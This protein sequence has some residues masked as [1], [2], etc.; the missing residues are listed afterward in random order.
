MQEELVRERVV[1]E[2]MLMVV[3]QALEVVL[4]PVRVVQMVLM[5]VPEA[6]VEVVEVAIMVALG[7]VVDLVQVQALVNIFKGHPTATVDILTLVETEVV[8]EEDKPEVT[9]ALAA[10]VLVVALALDLVKP[11]HIGMVRVLK[12]LMLMATVVAKE[13]VKMVGVE[14]AMVLDLDMVMQTP[15]SS[16]AEMMGP[17]L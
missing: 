4:G 15:R 1:V 3:A 11:P 2:D 16:V 6:E 12:T 8:G 14:E 17:N 9:M 7:M 10:T 5:R 13:T